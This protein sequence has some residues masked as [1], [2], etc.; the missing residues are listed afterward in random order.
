MI[1]TIACSVW[2]D[3]IIW[4]ENDGSFEKISVQQQKKI[5]RCLWRWV[6]PQPLVCVFSLLEI[7][8]AQWS[9]FDGPTEPRQAWVGQ[10]NHLNFL[11]RNHSSTWN[12]LNTIFPTPYRCGTWASCIGTRFS[13][14]WFRLSEPFTP[15]STLAWTLKR[16]SFAVVR[17]NTFLLIFI[18]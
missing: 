11:E 9:R 3:S 10:I 8:G 5:S 1:T 13:W 17:A 7:I 12:N 14:Y 2:S 15:T 4:S 16:D 6:C 18:Q